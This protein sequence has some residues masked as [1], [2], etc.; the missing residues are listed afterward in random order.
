MLYGFHAVIAALDNPRR[1]L[2]RLS[3][4]AEARKS[5]HMSELGPFSD[6]VHEAVEGASIVERRDLDALLPRGAVHQGIVLETRPLPPADIDDA[7]F[8]L[9][10]SRSV[11]VLDQLTDPHNVGAILRSAVAFG[12][13]AVVVQARHSPPAGG[14]LAKA[15]SGALETVPLVQVTNIARSLQHLKDTGYQAVGLDSEAQ[16]ALRAAPIAAPV[17]LVLGA[18]GKGL[19]RLTRERCDL[20]VRIPTRSGMVSLNVSNAAAIALYAISGRGDDEKTA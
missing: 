14:A 12:V 6:R 20:L 2:H 1:P 7:C 15:A 17:A 18:E 10:S 4:T 9:D 8:P 13:R 5:F 3:L 16:Q 11:L 19:R